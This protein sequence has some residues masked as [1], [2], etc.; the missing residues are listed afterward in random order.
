M[1][2]FY[3]CFIHCSGNRTRPIGSTKKWEPVPLPVRSYGK[4]REHKIG[5]K[6]VRID[7]YPVNR[8][9]QYRFWE[10]HGADRTA[11]VTG[12]SPQQPA[13]DQRRSQNNAPTAH[14][15]SSTAS[16]THLCREAPPYTSVVHLHRSYYDETKA[17]PEDPE[18]LDP[19]Q[20]RADDRGKKRVITTPQIDG[21]DME[22]DAGMPDVIIEP[23]NIASD[24]G[25][26]L[27][28]FDVDIGSLDDDY[29]M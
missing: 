22:I 8:S 23:S 17:T 4:N 28:A 15:R 19:P 5:E 7:G 18:L 1:S 11:L 14:F 29:A 6:S 26:P 13:A 27:G 21:G 24:D 2:C 12:T 25:L 10:T 9:N 3:L 16:C 20:S